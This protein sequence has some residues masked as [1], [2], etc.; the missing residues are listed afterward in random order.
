MDGVTRGFARRDS[1]ADRVP[2]WYLSRAHEDY[3][4]WLENQPAPPRRPRRADNPH[5]LGPLARW[6]A[7]LVGGCCRAVIRLG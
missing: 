1:G 7:D 4:D 2:D 3:L 6:C 5:T